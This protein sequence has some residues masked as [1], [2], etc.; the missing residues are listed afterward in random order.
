MSANIIEFTDPAK[1][2]NTFNKLKDGDDKI[3]LYFTA[4]WC[5]DC[6]TA[7]PEVKEKVLDITKLTVL[8]GI[9]EDKS[10]WVGR[11]D[12][13]YKTHKEFKAGGIPCLLLWGEGKIE[14]RAETPDDFED[15]ILL[16]HIESGEEKLPEQ[17]Q[18]KLE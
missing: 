5:P 10:T 16:Q 7:E 6:V 9:I 2:L 4:S 8:K 15:P 12:H 1:L 14:A 18:I 11:N 13:P 17:Q 3:I